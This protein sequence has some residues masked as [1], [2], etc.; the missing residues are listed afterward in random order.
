[1]RKKIPALAIFGVLWVAIV[2]ISWFSFPQW[3]MIPG[4]ALILV[5]TVAV[6]VIAFLKDA[7]SYIKSFS[8][9]QDTEKPA[10][11]IASQRNKIS[12]VNHSQV[13]TNS[14]DSEQIIAIETK[15]KNT[16]QCSQKAKDSPNAKQSIKEK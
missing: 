13:S 5:G 4:G 16:P 3:R 15:S 1:M 7:I 8:E 11:Q 12:R 14:P 6:G 2:I 10:K 9:M